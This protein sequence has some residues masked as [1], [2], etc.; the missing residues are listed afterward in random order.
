M[1]ILFWLVIILVGWLG[2]A[3][4][5]SMAG[6]WWGE[7]T[8]LPGE[9]KP[10]SVYAPSGLYRTEHDCLPE[11]TV[12]NHGRECMTCYPP[13][14]RT[15]N[16]VTSIRTTTWEQDAWAQARALER[17]GQQVLDKVAAENRYLKEVRAEAD[18]ASK[19]ARNAYAKSIES[20][21]ILPGPSRYSD[22]GCSC[23][24]CVP[25]T[26]RVGRYELPPAARIMPEVFKR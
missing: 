20:A 7:R 23:P 18:R 25:P 10:K 16:G 2:A 12:W 26:G 9:P 8:S 19:A 6:K 11:W 15:S 21:R 5:G 24:D 14:Y 17:K 3:K 4:L 13:D 1:E 22:P